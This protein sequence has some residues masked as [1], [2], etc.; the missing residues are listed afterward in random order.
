[1]REF[2]LLFLSLVAL[3]L[4][5]RL[6]PVTAEDAGHNPVPGDLKAK[7]EPEFSKKVTFSLEDAPL[8]EAIS[9]FRQLTKVNIILDPKINADDVHVNLKAQDMRLDDAVTW[10]CK[11]TNSQWELRNDAVYISATK[12]A[13]E[14]Q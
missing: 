5:Y 11:V 14:A 12:D 7:Y 9:F 2:K 10:L 1:M 8:G 3:F 13:L 4:A 6:S